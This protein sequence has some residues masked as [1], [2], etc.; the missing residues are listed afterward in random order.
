[1]QKV[2][3]EENH[4]GSRAGVFCRDEEG[5]RRRYGIV[6][7]SFCVVDTRTGRRF[8]GDARPQPETE[9]LARISRHA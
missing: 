3:C 6:G 5:A 1:V 7:E 8:F 9:L 2:V 4:M